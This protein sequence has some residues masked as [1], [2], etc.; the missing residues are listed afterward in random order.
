[1]NGMC[2][3]VPT[4]TQSALLTCCRPPRELP[5]LEEGRMVAEPTPSPGSH[6]S[7]VLLGMF[8]ASCTQM[9]VPDLM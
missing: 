3:L 7:A 5:P 1:M 8:M 4:E 6:L 2:A 9:A